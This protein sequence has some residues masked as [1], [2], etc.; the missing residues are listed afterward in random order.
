VTALIISYRRAEML[1]RCVAS[2]VRAA[3]RARDLQF[4][5]R[6]AING[7]DAES[8]A[9][10]QTLHREFPKVI[11][12]IERYDPGVSPAEARNRLLA[13]SQE[14]WIFFIDDDAYVGDD[15]FDQFVAA[16]R[17]YPHAV[18][19]G[20]PNLTPEHSSSFQKACGEALASRFSNPTSFSRYRVRGQ[21]RLADERELISCN[22]IIARQFLEER[23]FPEDFKS[24]EENWLM[25]SLTFKD[26]QLV[27]VPELKAWHERRKDLQGF[28]RQIFKYGYGRGQNIARRPQTFRWVYFVPPACMILSGFFF[29]WTLR[30]H[31]IHPIFLILLMMYG[32]ACW[33]AA[34][35]RARSV[36]RVV[37]LIPVIHVCYGLGLSIGLLDELLW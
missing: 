15:Y 35:R 27:H 12:S 34:Q 26:H 10:A 11:I 23:P 13:Q 32:G 18:A 2:L 9:M 28:A 5:I 25:Q 6:L 20:G 21:P 16:Q 31:Q 19:F 37:F 29:L 33:L 14:P 36:V 3:S 8:W 1:L 17:D 7:Q 30:N 24:G 4:Q 22:L